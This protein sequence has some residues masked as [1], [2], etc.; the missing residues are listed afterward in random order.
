MVWLST[1]ALTCVDIQCS[2]ITTDLTS[3]I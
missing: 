2:S 1:F 3:T